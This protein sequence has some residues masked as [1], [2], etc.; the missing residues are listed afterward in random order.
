MARRHQKK[1][2]GEEIEGRVIQ[3]KQ[4]NPP[5]LLDAIDESPEFHD[6]Y[7]E[8]NLFLS[9]KIKREM[10]HCSNSKKWSPQLQDELLH[11]IAPEFQQRF[12]RYRLGIAALKKTWEKVQYFSTQIQGQKEAL[13]QDGKLNIPFFIKENL[14][15]TPKLQNTCNLHPCHYAHQLAIKMS[16][17]VAVVDGIRPKLDQLTRTIWSLQRH[18]FTQ[19]STE[20]SKSPYDEN[21]KVDKLIVKSVLEITARHPEISQAELAFH[22]QKR[23]VQLQSITLTYPPSQIRKM[24][25]ALIAEQ[26]PCTSQRMEKVLEKIPYPTAKCLKSELANT[27]IDAPHLSGEAVIEEVFIFFQKATA[28][29][30]DLEEEEIERKIQNWTIQGDMLQ[31]WI[32]LNH[33]SA[34]FKEIEKKWQK[35]SLQEVVADVQKSFLETHPHLVSFVKEVETRTWIYLKYLWY[36]QGFG[37]ETA[38]FDRFIL[39]HKQM[40]QPLNLTPNQLIEKI[41][42]LCKKML[43]LMPFNRARA[44]TILV[45]EKEY[46]TH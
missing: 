34:L 17:C 45:T 4:L 11:K 28:A 27:L 35:K 39:W 12:P 42:S 38:T 8:L 22:V 7:S 16:E 5:G 36:T 14:K 2:L 41:E 33:D 43:P 10:R 13:T 19:L 9:Q 21:E 1:F 15:S 26:S 29:L 32:R 6:P 25:T 31:R 37:E 3:K 23:L 20:H 40:L 44:Q 24:L 30:K 46:G 18:L